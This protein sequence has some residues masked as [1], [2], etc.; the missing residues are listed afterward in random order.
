M[1]PSANQKSVSAA[2]DVNSASTGSSEGPLVGT[3]SHAATWDDP[4]VTSRRLGIMAVVGLGFLAVFAIA[5]GLARNLGNPSCASGAECAQLGARYAQGADGVVKD[6]AL[7]ARLYQRSCDFGNAEGC[8]G[9][10]LA[11]E[12]GAGVPQDYARAMD[13]FAR[14]CSGGF[15]EGCNNQGALYEHGRGVPVNLGDAQRLY[16][17]ACR[18]GSGVGC[19]NLGVL[20]AQGRGVPA[21]PA[22]ASRLFQEA[23]K[24]GSAVGCNNLVDS[25][26][27]P[28]ETVSLDAVSLEPVPSEPAVAP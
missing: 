4:S 18:R 17:Q 11:F 24:V 12:A 15:A 21:D 26:P 23:C 28:V 1:Q 16:T 2:R 5:G 19:S 10:G 13:H 25:T 3:W 6:A 7:A 20:Y 22:V 8:N 9:L 27:A 14:A